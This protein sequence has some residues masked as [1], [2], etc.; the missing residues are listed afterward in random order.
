MNIRS[1]ASLLFIT[2]T[3]VLACA[4]D[5]YH[6]DLINQLSTTFGLDT[7]SFVLFDNESTINETGWIYG[8]AS[9][10][11]IMNDDL[12]FTFA[13]ISVRS[14]GDNPWDAGVGIHNQASIA[15]GD[16]VLVHFW[17]R[18]LSES[19]SVN[20]FMENGVTFE[21]EFFSSLEITS[22][23]T[24]FFVPFKSLNAYQA[25]D[26]VLGFHI[27]NEKQDI[28]IGGYTA[29][30]FGNIDIKQVPNSFSPANYVGNESDAAWRAEAADRIEELRKVNLDVVVLDAAGMPL[31]NA[32]V[33]INMQKHDFGFGSA[34]AMSRFPGNRTFNQ[35]YIDRITDLD[36]KG[37]GFNIGVNEN[38]LKWDGWEEEWIGT[39]E[40]IRS[41]V[42]WL[43][44]RDVDMRG[45]VLVWPGFDN[46]PDDI[47]QNQNNI[48]YIQGRIS[49]RLQ[50]MLTSPVLGDV[51]NDWDILNE[52]TTNRDLES[53]FSND[54]NY[55]TGREL[56]V[57]ILTQAKA[58]APEK[59]FYI[60]DF[61]T[62]S[63]GGSSTAVIDRYKSYLDEMAASATPFDGIGFQCHI[64]S[65]PTSIIKIQ[66][67]LDDFS[68]RYNVP[69][70][71]TEYDIE[72]SVDEETQANYLNDFMTMVFS[73][74]AVESFIMWGFWDDNHWKNNAPMFR[75]D[76]SLKP[77][78]EVFINKVFDEWWTNETGMTD[79]DG[80]YQ[81]RAFK[82]DY[83]ITVKQ[84][85]Q[86]I[87]VTVNAADDMRVEL[88]TDFFS[89]TLD[90]VLQQITVYPNPGNGRF[91]LERPTDLAKVSLQVFNAT[92]K[93]VFTKESVSQTDELVLTENGHYQL[94]FISDNKVGMKSV[95]VTN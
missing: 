87:E 61:I 13:D 92:G 56:Y 54:P 32:E 44:D 48:E 11:F 84:D 28:Q 52:L 59:E 69:F 6:Q 34:F 20:V 47:Q 18:R 16:V 66:E 4:Q 79:E 26:M 35:T 76:W 46:L 58:L 77:S 90:P 63:G 57:E 60:N 81:T 30:N 80:M 10:E 51:I 75:S 12:G 3:S 78:G 22:D 38:A 83:Q 94:R 68:D 42:Q 89:S 23:W 64:G 37:H 73:H 27:A 49:S 65:I 85:G 14:P 9:R 62:L 53:V 95:I 45:H 8:D 7:P 36:G 41:A 25:G 1:I 50:S 71:I 39:P 19:G 5:D 24:E 67:T 43:A 40:E 15:I 33:S 93:L 72:P 70:Q 74:P 21:K 2:L 55:E 86:E 91:K 29:L 88:A 17:I 31:Q 82:G